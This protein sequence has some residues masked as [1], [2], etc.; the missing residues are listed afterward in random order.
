MLRRLVKQ[1]SFSLHPKCAKLKLNHL[2]F[3]DD[4]LIVCRGDVESVKL[5]VKCH[6]KFVGMPNTYLYHGVVGRQKNNIIQ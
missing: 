5:V 6:D 3:T 2:S 4:L 1:D